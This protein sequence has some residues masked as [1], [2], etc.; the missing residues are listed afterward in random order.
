MS[1][2]HLVVRNSVELGGHK[3]V[4]IIGLL[5]LVGCESQTAANK[6]P[7]NKTPATETPATIGD[8][9][10]TFDVD[11]AVDN[12]P[13]Y[14]VRWVDQTA[15]RTLAEI[16][17]SPGGR[18]GPS[19]DV[20]MSGSGRLAFVESIAGYGTTGGKGWMY[21]V[22][23]RTPMAGVGSVQLQ[24]PTTVHWR[25]GRFAEMPKNE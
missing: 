21:Q 2:K 4:C 16:L 9:T 25:Y 3:L 20:V 11:P 18:T 7:A 17:Q 22:D 12:G 15:G 8:V 6:T 1:L 23:G 5:C 19:L 14:T 24:P 10:M 13:E